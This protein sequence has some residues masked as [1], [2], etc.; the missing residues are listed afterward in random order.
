MSN[1]A[2]IVVA[3]A[4]VAVALIVAA[5]MR[6]RDQSRSAARRE[7]DDAHERAGRADRNRDDS[8]EQAEPTE[9]QA[10]PEA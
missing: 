6:G 9:G 8:R 7:S 10:K 4:V 5:S 2:I 3:V 1:A